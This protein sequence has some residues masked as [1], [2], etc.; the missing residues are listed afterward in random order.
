[1]RLVLDA[2][3]KL[4]PGTPV[5][6]KISQEPA[7]LRLRGKPVPFRYAGGRVS[8]VVRDPREREYEAVFGEPRDTGRFPVGMGDAFHYNRP[9]GLDPLTVGMKNDQPMAVDWDGDGRTDLVQRN[10]YSTDA[11]EPWWG[12]YF[13]RNTGSNARPVFERFVRIEA[14]GAPIADPYASFALT[15]QDNDGHTDVLAGIGSGPRRGQLQVY[16]N[17]GR[18]DSRRLPILESGPALKW[19]AGGALTYGMRLFE[20]LGELFTLRMKVEYFPKQ[21][22]D[23]TLFRHERAG[24]GWGPG[25]PVRLGGNGVYEEWPSTRVDIDGDGKPEWAGSSG[26]GQVMAWD[27]SGTVRP[28]FRVE[29]HGFM[30]PAAA[31]A[32]GFHGLFVSY[33]GG[34]IRYHELSAKGTWAAPRLLLARDMPVSTGGYSSVDVIDW[35]GD[36]DLDFAAGN[37]TGYVQLIENISSGGR[38]MFATARPIPLTAGAEM[39]AARWMFIDDRDP[40]RMLGQ[41][42]PAFVD[43][44][45]DGD[46]DVL[47]GNNSNRIA[48]FENTGTRRAPRYAQHRKLLHDDGEHFSFRARPAPFDVNGDGLPDLIAGCAGPRDRNDAGEIPVCLYERYLDRAGVRRLRRGAIL[49]RTPI[50][51]HH[52]FEAVDWDGDGDFDILANE[53]MQGVL[54]RNAGTSAKPE[55]RRELILFDGKPLHISHHEMSMKAVDWDRDGRLDLITGGESGWIYYFHRSVLDGPLAE[56]AVAGNP[57][58]R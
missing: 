25:I 14:D 29:R 47:V 22:V 46:L 1:M 20:P 6:A 31:E 7:G 38:T 53:R 27:R 12:L 54:Y 11:G 36:G 43:W 57:A 48:W 8:W 32:P 19:G 23:F 15:D 4:E 40:E 39:Y 21:E 10:L 42:K 30:T 16:R 18:R 44:D 13:F 45:G 3:A 9:G 56:A 2:D 49:F 50:P 26:D 35:E 33:M 28:L 58:A 37:E 51:Y 24:E 52:G 5:F 55:F 17:T 34:W 41:A